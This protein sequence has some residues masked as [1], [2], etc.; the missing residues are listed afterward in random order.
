MTEFELIEKYFKREQERCRFP[1]EL[2]VGD[3]CALMSVPRGMQL[4][5]SVGTLV[6]GVHFEHGTS[7]VDV[8]SK[9]LCTNLADLAAAGALPAWVSVSLTLPRPS[10]TWVRKFSNRLFALADAVQVQVVGAKATRGPLAVTVQ[11]YGMVEEG[12]ALM[13][14]G[15]QVDDRIFVTGTLGGAALAARQLERGETPD[16]DCLRRLRAPI[17]RLGIGRAI[18]GLATSCIDLS[19]GLNQDLSHLLRQSG[20]GGTLK[21]DAIPLPAASGP[22]GM[23]GLDLALYGG[24]DYELCF[25]VPEDK[26]ARLADIPAIMGQISCVGV[27]E[28]ELG[29]RGAS[30]RKEIANLASRDYQHFGSSEAL[31]S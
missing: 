3:D 19:N 17:P 8:A 14:R 30:A 16:K 18:Q 20:V 27:V 15:A 25:T 24:D 28:E 31:S 11:I 6:S 1:A 10:R 13:R 12:M 2:G 23:T 22:L 29:L 5:T 7:P 9:A 26:A 21:L 4:A